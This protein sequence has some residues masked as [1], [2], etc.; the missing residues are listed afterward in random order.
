MGL[1][2]DMAK[3]VVYGRPA[4]L[5]TPI[6]FNTPQ[7]ASQRDAIVAGYIHAECL[8]D[9]TYKLYTLT[10]S[11]KGGIRFENETALQQTVENVINRRSEGQDG[12]IEIKTPMP[13]VEGKT[14][15]DLKEAQKI[16]EELG[17]PEN[18]ECLNQTPSDQPAPE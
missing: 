5:N 4:E 3:R 7:K 2:K 16:I 13:P 15:F 14:T 12:I 8:A 10:F 1:L 18:I 11:N 9:S 6:I 17:R